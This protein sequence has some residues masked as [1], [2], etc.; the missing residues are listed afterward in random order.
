MD[1]DRDKLKWEQNPDKLTL[2][3][4][5]VEKGLR[6]VNLLPLQWRDTG[7]LRKMGTEDKEVAF[8]VREQLKCMELCLKMDKEPTGNLSVRLKD[9]TGKGDTI[10]GVCYRPPDWEE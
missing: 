2:G 6:Y 7:S 5:S 9:R 1:K 8:C 3:A 10:V 4:Y